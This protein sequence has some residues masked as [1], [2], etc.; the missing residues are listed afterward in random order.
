MKDDDRLATLVHQ[1]DSKRMSLHDSGCTYKPTEIIIR[2]IL[3]LRV[4]R[5]V[6]VPEEAVD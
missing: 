1:A 4:L 2:V 3:E 5:R 6:H